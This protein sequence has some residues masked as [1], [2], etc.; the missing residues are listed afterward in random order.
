MNLW[1]REVGQPLDAERIIAELD[2][3]AALIAS[4]PRYR[5]ACN[6]YIAVFRSDE[7]ANLTLPPET[8]HRLGEHDI[9]VWVSVY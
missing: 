2:G 4:R 3:F 7:I 8:M 9:S 6:A 1:R 5:L